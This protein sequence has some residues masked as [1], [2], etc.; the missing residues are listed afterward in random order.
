MGRR[1]W[2]HGV[3]GIEFR[4]RVDHGRPGGAGGLLPGGIECPLRHGSDVTGARAQS[5]AGGSKIRPGEDE[6]GP[7][8][9]RR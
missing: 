4:P 7:V 3:H 9:V 1:R 8:V 6:V 5:P 2:L